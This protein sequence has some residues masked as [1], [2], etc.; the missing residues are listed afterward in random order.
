[1][2]LRSGAGGQLLMLA[3]HG[4]PKG[5][6]RAPFGF[7]IFLLLVLP[8]KLGY[9]DLA[10]LTAGQP[11]FPERSQRA[12]LVSPFGTI[13]GQRISFP[14]PVGATIP[15]SLGYTLAGFDP[16]GEFTGAIPGHARDERVAHWTSS[17]RGWQLAEQR[18]ILH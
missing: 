9:L 7:S 13:H 5:G 1:M 16:N 17:R 3:S 12:A 10:G 8:S 11:P 18:G 15:V 6:L 4:R 2:Q 14:Q